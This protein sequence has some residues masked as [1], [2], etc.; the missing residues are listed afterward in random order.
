[1]SM[2]CTPV[3][4]LAVVREDDLVVA[5]RVV[6][7]V[8]EGLEPLAQVVRVQDG[9]L[10]H[11]V[12][13]VP[14]GQDVRQRAHEDPEVPVER[15]HLPDRV[16]PVVVQPERVPRPLDGG[17]RQ[18]RH[19]RRADADGPRSGTA[20]AVRRRERLV[21]VHVHDVHAHVGRA[22]LAHERVE[23]R[24][25][26]VEIRALR[27]DELRDVED[28]LLEDAERVRH[29]DHERRDVLR[30]L[31]LELGEVDR[32]APGRPELDDRVAGEMRGRGVRA[33]RGVGHEDVL[34]RVA[35]LH[36]RGADHEG[37]RELAVRAGRRLERD[38]REPGEH[39]QRLL[40][41]EEELE[42]ALREVLGGVGV[43]VVEAGEARDLLVDP[44]GCA[45]SC[46]SRASR[47]PCRS[48]S[49]SARGA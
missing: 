43:R 46:T 27:V 30:E 32:P 9:V 47:A 42:I 31:R 1:M 17:H 3:R 40:E 45:S 6:L 21:Q 15:A 19:E 23:V 41:P 26:E 22:H 7:Q 39:L 29:G 44:A 18:E 5:R 20:A 25:V 12:D 36:V 24:A 8:V 16:G 37:A 33:V 10:G 48:R 14:V 35:R 11:L 28:A 34:A 2:L 49:S 38:A 13:R 4:R